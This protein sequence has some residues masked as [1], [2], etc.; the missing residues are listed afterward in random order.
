[1]VA[2]GDVSICHI[3]L[4]GPPP[5]PGQSAPKA[6]NTGLVHKWRCALILHGVDMSQNHGWVSAV[7]TEREIE[8]T[9]QAVGQAPWPISRRRGR[10]SPTSHAEHGPGPGAAEPARGPGRGG[11]RRR[12]RGALRHRAW[13]CSGSWAAGPGRPRPAGVADR[14]RPRSSGPGRLRQA[15]RDVPR[16]D[17]GVGRPRSGA[18][19]IKPPPF[20]DGRLLNPLPDD[21]LYTVVRD[22]AAAVG[23]APQM[24]AFGPLLTDREIRDV[25]AY[26]RTLAAATLPAAGRAR[27]RPP[28]APAPAQPIEFS[29]AIHAGSY[30]IDCQ[31]C[32]ADARRS[33]VRRPAVGRPL[34]GLPQDRRGAGQPRGA[35]APPVLGPEGSRSPGCASTSWRGSSTFPTSGTCRRASP[36][37]RAT[38]R[39]EAMQ[40]V[41]QVAPLTMGW[42][43][44]CHAERRGPLDCVACHH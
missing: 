13:R 39:V 2:Y 44:A 21:F 26:V 34:H 30:G 22:G 35:E 19:P 28:I 12:P 37:R 40:R 17:R 9:V 7:H 20:T 16:R 18:L 14:G 1:M 3:S 4:D 15:L 32:H 41:A 43:V 8:E 23:L 33:A 6:K 11:A 31:Y 42:C 38:A 5:A 27:R 36:A 24:P 29:H 25:V 10:S